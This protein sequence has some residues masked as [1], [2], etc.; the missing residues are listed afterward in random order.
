M[1]ASGLLVNYT[2]PE[3]QRIDSIGYTCPEPDLT[4]QTGDKFTFDCGFDIGTGLRTTAGEAV[5]DIV[6]VISYSVADCAYACS[7]FNVQQLK[8]DLAERCGSITFRWDVNNITKSYGG[9]CWL[10]NGTV[11]TGASLSPSDFAISGKIV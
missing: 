5:V 11:A 10:K 1:T 4:T 7:T 8:W 3:W 9:N 6:G 2:V